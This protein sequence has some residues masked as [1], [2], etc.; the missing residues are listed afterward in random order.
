MRQY[1]LDYLVCIKTLFCSFNVILI[2][3]FLP[4]IK[5]FLIALIFS[6]VVA[7]FVALVI[8]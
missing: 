3:S 1:P 8:R 4:I 6:V 2:T 5:T 7:C